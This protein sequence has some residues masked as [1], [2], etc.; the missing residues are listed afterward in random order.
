V[1][2]GRPDAPPDLRLTGFALGVWLAALAA[3]YLPAMAGGAAAAVLAVAAALVLTLRAR[4]VPPWVATSRPA[5]RPPG[6]VV[7]N[8]VVAVLLGGGLGAAVTAARVAERDAGPLRE[9]VASRASVRAELIVTDDPRAVAGAAGR[10]STYAVPARLRLLETAEVRVRAG[11]R[12]L[13]LGSHPGWRG[14]LPGQDVE[15]R[16]RLL[17]ARGGDLRSAVLSAA[18]APALLGRSSPPQRLAG[19]L[20]DGLQVACAPLPDAPGGLLPGLVVGDTSRLDPAVEAD[21]RATGLTHLTAVSGSNC[22]IVM[23]A[24]LLLAR[25]A[26][27]A[28][29]TA[30][31]L[32]LAALVGFVILA[33]PS[34]SVLRAAAM[35]G[36]ALLALASGRSRAAL[37][38]LGAA[39]AVLVVVDPELAGAPGFALSVLATAGL[40]LLAPGW[41]DALR[42]RGVPSGLAEALAVPAAAQAACAPVVAA[43]S[44]AVSLV[45]V[46][47]NLLAVPAVAPA[48]VLGVGAAVVSPVWPAGA[49]FL[50]WL[51]SWPARWLVTVARHGAE[52]PSGALPWPGGAVGGVL[53][54]VVILAV[55]I[56]V[57]WPV[58][59]RLAVV[60][61]LAAVVSALPVRL[62]TAGW[63]PP[64]WLAVAC[65]VGQG[66]AFV[67]ATGGGSGVVVDAGP[68]PAAVDRC[69][70]R[71]GVTSV[72]LLI[73]SHFH[74]DH[75]GGVAGVFRGRVVGA[76]VITD[77][78]EPAAGRAAVAA[79]AAGSGVPVAPAGPGWAAVV[80]PVRLSALAAAEPARGT[81]SDA[82]NNSLVVRAVVGRFTFLL[83]GD[84]ETEQQ[85]ALLARYGAGALRADVVKIAHHGSAFQDPEFLTAPGARAAL[86]SVGAGNDY[87]HPNPAVLARLAAAGVRVMRTDRD[88]DVAF[89]VDDAGRLAVVARGIEPGQRPR[90]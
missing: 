45:A 25:A 57:R 18:A 85:H 42:R 44:G 11:T 53:L 70:R 13:V 39:V 66:D 43:L 32:A 71:L 55:L 89:V 80:G 62:L 64:R 36:V 37:P 30:A 73:V 19:R 78:A 29:R 56:A 38:A 82:N 26:R 72:P 77:H 2:I 88:G 58:V 75:V 21:F 34:P 81:R 46:P 28:P 8:A 47:A 14:L 69:L 3:L 16:G 48:T 54:G 60:V 65:D 4:R 22:A 10:P 59:R 1:S 20:R 79:A 63:P 15:V 68:D 83:A 51:G 90:R 50:A 40:L 6:P 74:V 7:A 9:L 61:T 52:V 12:V 76:V 23:G 5:E 67:L 86:V 33:R 87:G 49:G 84:A 24:V 35:G 31:T 41:R 27:A 17:A